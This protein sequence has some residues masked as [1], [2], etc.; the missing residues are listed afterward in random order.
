M[1]LMSCYINDFGCL[2]NQEFNFSNGL[3]CI[4]LQNGSGKSTLAAFIRAMFYGIPKSSS[5]SFDR[6][7]YLPYN[8]NFCKG[9]INF[10]FNDKIYKIERSFGKKISDDEMRVYENGSLCDTLGSVPGETLFG[11]DLNSF[12]R[13][14]FIYPEDVEISSTSEI[15]AKMNSFVLNTKDDFNLDDVLLK[16]ENYKKKL[17]P[18][19]LSNQN[20]LIAVKKAEIKALEEKKAICLSIKDNLNNKYKKNEAIKKEIEELKLKASNKVNENIL[21]TKWKYYDNIKVKIEKNND[22]IKKYNEKYKFGIPSK[23]EIEAIRKNIYDNDKIKENISLYQFNDNDLNDYNNYLDKFKNGIPTDIKQEEIKSKIDELNYFN[24]L[25][26]D[27]KNSD[28]IIYN[29]YRDSDLTDEKINNI[30]ILIKEYNKLCQENEAVSENITVEV[31][32]KSNN[33]SAIILGI[34]GLVLLISSAILFFVNK[35]LLVLAIVGLIFIFIAGFIYLKGQIDNSKNTEKIIP[36]PKKIEYTNKIDLLKNKIDMLIKPYGFSSSKDG[37]IS[38]AFYKLNDM[39][40]KYKEIKSQREEKDN[41][42]KDNLNKA[43]DIQNSL[44]S[45]FQPYGYSSCNYLKEYECLKLDIVKYSYLNNKNAENKKN[46]EEANKNFGLNLAQI[47]E[48]CNKYK[49]DDVKKYLNEVANDIVL[50]KGLYDQNN[51][52]INETTTYKE[53]NALMERPII[54]EDSIDNIN[55]KINSLTDEKIGLLNE[56]NEDEGQ[57][58]L[59]SMACENLDDK[60]NELNKLNYDYYIVGEALNKLKEADKS[61]KYKYIEPLLTRF[62]EY[63]KEFNLKLLNDVIMDA[64]YNLKLI[65]NGNNYSYKHLSSGELTIVAL[66]YRLAIMDNILKNQN[67]LIIMDDLFVNLDENNLKLALEFIKKLSLKR[68]IIYFTC[69]SSR[70]IVI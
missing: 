61:L 66:C 57:L 12:N 50:L 19:R 52:L 34:V 18:V 39:Y 58:E 45:F 62:K 55:S 25:N 41:I 68:Q 21:L 40:Q 37:S 14:L 36:N 17:K 42:R 38:V 9:S 60:R 51:S 48:F 22:E 15:N 69:H 31:P 5:K 35:M 65:I 13:C 4:F 8:Q 47:Q 63:T 3:N 59:L 70:Q 53:E 26:Y 33:K 30:D 49:I 32:K 43:I 29:Q 1:K 67:Q 27:L 16:L 7:H 44:K 2:H 64:D 23:E 11:L 6:E 56:I 28:L 10:E 54:S 46:L 24:S 20:G